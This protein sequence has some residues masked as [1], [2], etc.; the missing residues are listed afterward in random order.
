M[1]KAVINITANSKRLNEGSLLRMLGEK[2]V[3][4]TNLIHVYIIPQCNVSVNNRDINTKKGFVVLR[5]T[6]RYSSHP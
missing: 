1:N 5:R 4:Y 3:L 2:P 6:T